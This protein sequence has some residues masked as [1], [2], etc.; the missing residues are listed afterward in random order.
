MLSRGKQRV[1]FSTP[2]AQAALD[3]WRAIPLP[4]L[5]AEADNLHFEE[6]A[7]DARLTHFES[8]CNVADSAA[9]LRKAQIKYYKHFIETSGTPTTLDKN[10]GP[11]L[12]EGMDTELEIVRLESLEWPLAL[13]HISFEKFEQ[14]FN[15]GDTHFIS[16]FVQSWNDERDNRP[17][18]AAFRHEVADL[19]EADDWAKQLRDRLGLAHYHAVNA[20]IPVA[21]MKYKV[22]DVLRAAR[23]AVQSVA[24][25]APIV[26]DNGP[27]SYFFPSPRSLS[28]G[29]TMSLRPIED[30]SN[31][32]AEFLHYRLPYKPAMLKKVGLIDQPI[33]DIAIKDLR[34]HHLLA[35]RLASG[36]YEFGLEIV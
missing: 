21:L 8:H 13:K 14:S 19:L 23:K 18:F 12:W 5:R 11:A 34:N 3:A 2:A 26:F 17:A 9:S 6:R 30:D 27:W 35:I 32:L 31:L 33:P 25:V 7:S 29:R 4:K 20:P 22:S 15:S 28:C 16:E 10:L 24:F 36:S 1:K